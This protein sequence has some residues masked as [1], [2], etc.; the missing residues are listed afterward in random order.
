ME[1]FGSYVNA[2]NNLV[3][4]D[5]LVYLCLITGVYFTA[6]MKFPQIRLIGDMV[7][8][9]IGKGSQSGISSFQAFA[10]TVGSRVG[11]G[12]IAGVSTA[13]RPDRKSVV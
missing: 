2:F 4:S 7:R 1:S 8:L 3:W 5:A 13:R 12:N 9:L 11:M 10:T 6:R